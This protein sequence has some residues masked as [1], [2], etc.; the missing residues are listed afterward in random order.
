MQIRHVALAA[1]VLMAGNA[2]HRG[3]T[4]APEEA[5]Q[6]APEATVDGPLQDWPKVD[7]ALKQD[8]AVEARVRE[9]LSGMTLRQKVGQMTQG[10][11]K[12][13][14]PDDVRTYYLGSVLNGGGS[15]P[16]MD[17]HAS[18][19]DWLKLADAYYDASMATD[20][21]TPIPV[22]WGTDAMHGH[23]NVYRA[24]IFPHAIGMGAAHDAE[25]VGRIA[26]VTGRA[27]RATGID[28][29][30]A[31]AVPVVQDLRWGRT[32]ESWSEDPALVREYAVAYTR[33]LQGTFGD[34]GN[35]IATAKHFIADG[36]T[37]HGKDQ[38][39]A[40][41]S[42][43]DLI[44]LHGPGY[45]GAL[46]AGSQTVMAT[47]NS[48]VDA[49][50][51]QDH[52]KLHGIKL[53]L[54]DALKTKMG[55][56]GFIV[57]DWNGIGQVAGC[58]NAS[59]PQAINA[60][61]DMVMVPDDW[62]AFID[63]TVRQV[64]AGEIPMSRIDDAVSRILRVK[65]RAGMFDGRKPSLNANAGKPE[66]LQ[67][68]P[69]AREAVRKSLVLLK[70][71]GNA[72]PLARGKK[73]LVVGAS[74]DSISNQTGGWTLTWQGTENTNADFPDAESLL[75]G[76]RKAAGEANVTYRADAKG[77]DVS[78][79]DAVIAVLGET[80]YAEGVG[81]IAQY[82]TVSHSRRYPADLAA[83]QAV[84]GKGKPVVTV[85]LSG[86][87]A[88][89]ND[90]V[91]LSDAFVVA[92]L[93]GTEGGGVADVLFA[94]AD[95]K[96]AHDFTARLSFS[97]PAVVCPGLRA[98]G[99]DGAKPQFA[100][101]YGLS[102]AKGGSVAPLPLD[103]AKACG[104]ATVLPVFERGD[105]PTFALH[106][107]DGTQVH[108]LGADVNATL[109]WPQGKPRVK[110]RTVQVNT[111]QDAREVTW[112]GKAMLFSRNPSRSD[113]RPFATG[114]A[115]VFDVS[116]V[117]PPRSKVTLLV[118][119]G[120]GCE[121]R[122]DLT[123]ALAAATPGQKRTIKVPLK[124]FADA[125]AKLESVEVPFAVEADAPFAAAFANIRIDAVAGKDAD[126][127]Q[128]RN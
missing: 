13:V 124:C 24:T 56:D 102:Y 63:N 66:A 8:P 57:S 62:K 28:W 25:L 75:A 35:A 106:V 67:E 88:Y 122:Q 38:G 54:T 105:T 21:K 100:R 58:T 113:L 5:R 119:C 96:P 101:G 43:K 99:P 76:F 68:R 1:A 31:P 11:I 72:L 23:S 83:L 112:L 103:D 79:F 4:P 29:L 108:A 40:K 125:G 33:G 117:Q 80:P 93:P 14:T 36:G 90:L 32:Y 123:S 45:F 49:D 65:L 107:G 19:G 3:Q 52:G 42:M 61:I 64:E 16:A 9:I 53:L 26:S 94:G 12:Q 39:V 34:D 92:W 84:A 73:V 109:E 6:S 37:E 87:P 110:V 121:G 48:W 116:V 77:V 17:K 86:R 91:N 78:K 59:C 115:L 111:Q 126:A 51:G 30:F 114:G 2:C 128:C 15:W 18:V 71:E 69:L 81:D 82:D 46:G 98:A 97:W 127:L 55:F 7:S 60:G 44:N 104:Q 10:E 118:G 27:V 89:A 20:L 22:I 120:P 50:T 95:G 85:L 47:F 70:N 41:W 74:A